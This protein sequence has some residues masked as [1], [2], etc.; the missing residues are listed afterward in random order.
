MQNDGSPSAV[1]ARTEM[2]RLQELRLQHYS[3]AWAPSEEEKSRQTPQD[4][5]TYRGV[6]DALYQKKDIFTFTLR[7]SAMYP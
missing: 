3:V 5:V 7:L 1:V 6:R 4:G 2:N